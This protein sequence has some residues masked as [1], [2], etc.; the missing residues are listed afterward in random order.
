[1]VEQD[2]V[3]VPAGLQEPMRS[4]MPRRRAGLA[5]IAATT[6]STGSRST[7]TARLKARSR[8]SVDP[9]IEPPSTSRATPSLTSTSNGPSR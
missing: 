6:S 2:Q 1:M 8:V 3:G 9:A 5:E 4:D 7:V